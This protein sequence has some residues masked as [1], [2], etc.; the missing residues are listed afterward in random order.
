MDIFDILNVLWSDPDA[1]LWVLIYILIAVLWVPGI[2]INLKKQSATFWS[3]LCLW[4]IGAFILAGGT[5]WWYF[6]QPAPGLSGVGN[7]LLFLLSGIFALVYMGL[8][9]WT[10]VCTVLSQKQKLST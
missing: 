8:L 7:V 5:T 10:I 4:G 2:L 9:A 6:I 1:R 3:F